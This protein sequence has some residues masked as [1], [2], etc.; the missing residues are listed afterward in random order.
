MGE[1]AG[2]QLRGEGLAAT[3]MQRVVSREGMRIRK[4]RL[5]NVRVAQRGTTRDNGG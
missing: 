4:G 5:N 2:L 3:V 1:D